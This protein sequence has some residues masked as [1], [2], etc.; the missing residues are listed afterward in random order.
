MNRKSKRMNLVK[1]ICFD[2]DGTLLKD[3]KE[4]TSRTVKA[5]GRA[6]DA[7]IYLVPT[8]GRL[9]DGVPEE[10]RTLP[11]KNPSAKK[12]FWLKSGYNWTLFL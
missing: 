12:T 4:L 3:N 8:T 9:Y 7:G 2:V 10:I 11:F 1:L 5:L 6:A